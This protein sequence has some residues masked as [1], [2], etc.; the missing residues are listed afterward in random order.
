MHLHLSRYWCSNIHPSVGCSSSVSLYLLTQSKASIA[1]N[2]GNPDYSLHTPLGGRPCG[3]KPVTTMC[4][5]CVG[6]KS[7]PSDDKESVGSESSEE[8]VPA[9][10]LGVIVQCLC[11]G[12]NSNKFSRQFSNFDRRV[13]FVAWTFGWVHFVTHLIRLAEVDANS[14]REGISSERKQF[15]KN[16]GLVC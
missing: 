11:S 4:E 9:E 5:T 10:K 12:E 7:S 13:H 16:L 6:L 3:Y 1:L 2:L 15:A 8:L 14:F